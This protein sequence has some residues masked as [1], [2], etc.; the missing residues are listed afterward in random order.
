[1]FTAIVYVAICQ[2][3][4]CK[5]VHGEWSEFPLRG[6]YDTEEQ[7]RSEAESV[8]RLSGIGR[9]YTYRIECKR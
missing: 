2:G 1:M 8:V 7:C 5:V 4:L 9:D 6:R 3:W